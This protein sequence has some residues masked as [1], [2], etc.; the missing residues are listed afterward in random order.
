MPTFCVS[1]NRSSCINQPLISVWI[2]SLC[3]ISQAR[4][5][6]VCFMTSVA[7]TWASLSNNNF[8]VLTW[9]DKAAACKAKKTKEAKVTNKISKRLYLLTLSMFFFLPLRISTWLWLNAIQISLSLDMYVLLWVCAW[10][11][12]PGMLSVVLVIFFSFWLAT[13]IS[14]KRETSCSP[15]MLKTT[16]LCNQHIVTGLF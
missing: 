8:T 15:W 5:S 14:D 10:M 9:P 3:P 12:R 1:P 2:T 11:L 6:G 13:G 4:K 16:P 7:S